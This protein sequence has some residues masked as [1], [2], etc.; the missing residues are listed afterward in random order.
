[1]KISEL[2]AGQGKIDI[3]VKI[4]SKGDV[5]TFNKYGKDLRVA[6]AVASD[7]SG[8]IQ[9]TLWN[10]DIEKINAG[11]KVK[12]K[13]GYVS[14]FNGQLQLGSGKFGSLELV[15]DEMS[16]DGKSGEKSGKQVK[17]EK[18][19]ENDIEEEAF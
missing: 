7:D 12:I 6:N 8:E 15:D 5:R 2:K 1:M 16:N 17:K 9:L 10:D 4:K 14:E 19:I 3:E 13:N 11:N 18:K